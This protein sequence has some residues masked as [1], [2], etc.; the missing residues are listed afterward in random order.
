MMFESIIVFLGIIAAEVHAPTFTAFP[1]ALGHETTSGE[2]VLTLPA[3]RILEDF[4][5]NVTAPEIY[6]FDSFIQQ[7]PFA[8][9]SDI[10][11]HKRAQ[12][13][14]YISDIQNGAMGIGYI[15]SY[16]APLYFTGFVFDFASDVLAANS[17]TLGGLCAANWAGNV[18]FCRK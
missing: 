6:N 3:Y 12:G 18:P 17:A 7:T 1:A 15:V 13:I 2:H 10:A 5:H 14:G 4:I 8:Y 9:K 11:P 16:A